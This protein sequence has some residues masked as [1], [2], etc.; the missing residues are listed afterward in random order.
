MVNEEATYHPWWYY[1]YFNRIFARG[2]GYQSDVKILQDRLDLSEM[3]VEEIG[4]GLG[5]HA[6]EFLKIGVPRLQL[7]END[8]SAS[9]YLTEKYRNFAQVEVVRADGFAENNRTA[10]CIVVYYSIIQQCSDW[11]EFRSRI[12]GLIARLGI[13]GCACFEFIDV[14]RSAS[15]Y[16]HAVQGCVLSEP[17]A[18]I[19]I[20]SEYD[21]EFMEI[22]YSGTLGEESV[23]YRVPLLNVDRD[24]VRGIVVGAG[25]AC[26]LV[27]LDAEGRRNVAIVKPGS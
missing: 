25:A 20:R 23:D 2:D 19:H 17:N 22:L 4:A 14:K 12:L 11:D 15:V 16:R 1:K 5:G 26:E 24:L 8:N 7:V 13:R 27:S 21:D 6:D 9:N 10:D 3:V 18:M